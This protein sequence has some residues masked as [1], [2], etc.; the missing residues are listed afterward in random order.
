MEERSDSEGSYTEY[1]DVP[2]DKEP[3]LTGQTKKPRVRDVQPKG[4]NT[5]VATSNGA[6]PK[7]I[8]LANMAAGTGNLLGVC[9]CWDC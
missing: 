4:R 1:S 7:V 5:S 6:T 2:S 8:P 3:L 9:A